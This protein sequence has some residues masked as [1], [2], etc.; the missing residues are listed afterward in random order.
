MEKLKEFWDKLTT[1]E[2]VALGVLVAGV[3]GYA[4]YKR[5]KSSSSSSSPGANVGQPV[6]QYGNP[7]YPTNLGGLYSSQPG[8]TFSTST[9]TGAPGAPARG[10]LNFSVRQPG[11]AGVWDTQHSGVPLRDQPGGG[12]NIIGYIPFG[13]SISPLGSAINGSANQAGGSTAWYQVNYGGQ[14]GYISL[15]D[16]NASGVPNRTVNA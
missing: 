8:G 11:A 4:F 6:D 13:A 3:V 9:G 16:L 1:H 14:T 2:K 7:L 5:S 12:G 10:Q 15:F